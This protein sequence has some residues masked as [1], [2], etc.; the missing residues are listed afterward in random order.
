MGTL[1]AGARTAKAGAAKR[2]RA[3]REKKRSVAMNDFPKFRR[4][5]MTAR[6][7][8]KEKKKKN[9]E[10][11]TNVP[12][13]PVPGLTMMARDGLCFVLAGDGLAGWLGWV[14]G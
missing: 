6:P 7:P 5:A 3:A 14:G 10:L 9:S 2:G 12:R 13:W 1:S 11:C 8:R 4:V